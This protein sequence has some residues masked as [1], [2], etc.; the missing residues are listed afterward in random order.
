MDGKKYED[1]ACCESGGVMPS[2]SCPAQKAKKGGINVG[3]II[4]IFFGL[5]LGSFGSCYLIK[6]RRQAKARKSKPK[7]DT[8]ELTEPEVN[9]VSPYEGTSVM[10]PP[11]APPTNPN[12]DVKQNVTRY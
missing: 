11:S 1:R 3:M 7:R 12:F 9:V 8:N 5:I 4:V 10:M 2:E 6:K